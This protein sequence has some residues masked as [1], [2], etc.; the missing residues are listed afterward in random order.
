MKKLFLTSTLLLLTTTSVYAATTGTLLLR[1]V[2]AQKVSLVVTPQSIASTLDLSTSQ[3]DLVVASVNEQSNSKTGYKVTI[4]SANSSKLKRTDGADV[5][6]YTLKYNGSAVALSSST[7][8]TI[9][10]SS[11][12]SVNVNKSVSISYTGVAAEAMVEG[13]YADTITFSIAAN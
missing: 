5:L 6:T 8:T 4:S 13:T 10:N 7:G 3:T 12:S 1:G 9:T 11:P 2:V